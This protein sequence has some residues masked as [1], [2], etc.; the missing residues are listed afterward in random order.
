MHFVYIIYS[1]TFNRYYIGESEDISER[2]KQ[3]STGFFKNSFTI[4]VL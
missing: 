4:L 1:D 2:I 3:H